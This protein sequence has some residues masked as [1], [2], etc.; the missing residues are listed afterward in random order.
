MTFHLRLISS[1][2][3]LDLKVKST[4]SMVAPLATSGKGRIISMAIARSSFLMLTPE[5]RNYLRAS[6]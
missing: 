6:L 2:I 4:T 3:D 5:V 1:E